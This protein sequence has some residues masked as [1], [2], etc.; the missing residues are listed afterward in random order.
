[1]HGQ[2]DIPLNDTGI[3][4][5]KKISDEL[6]N[7][8]F[9]LCFS[10]PLK[11]ARSTAY[12]ILLN[13]KNTDIFYDDRL[14]ELS[15]GLLE[16]KHLNSEKLLK[17]EDYN[18]IKKFKIETKKNFLSRV[19]QFIEEVEK[20]Y[21]G[22]KILIVAHS[23][24][25]KMLSFCFEY[26]KIQLHKAY[27]ALHIQNCKPYKPRSIKV[28]VK[29]MKIGFFPMV[30]DILH[31]GHVLSLEEAKKHCDLLIVGLHCKPNYKTPQQSIYERYMQ[32]RAVKWVDEVIPYENIDK[33]KDMFVSL[34]YDVYF[35]GED[36]KNDEWEFKDQLQEMDKEII[37][38]KRKHN[39]SSSRIKNECK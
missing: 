4:Q 29:Q 33:D 3:K 19:K 26:P 15:K 28:K 21:K 36:H 14:M 12:S 39:Y 16:G 34:D 24:T 6:K 5:A 22:K 11:R 13:H 18:F 1:M 20:N 23:G 25:I 32:L 37:Y 9:D 31:S 8:H 7:E 2:Y 10:S 35:L 17:T 27:Y 30:A 38:L